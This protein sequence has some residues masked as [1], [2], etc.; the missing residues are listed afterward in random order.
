LFVVL[1]V[2]IAFA[3]PVLGVLVARGQ[4]SGAEAHERALTKDRHPVAAVL[5]QDVFAIGG[6][7][8]GTSGVS[9]DVS[10]TAADGTTHTGKADVQTVGRLG[11]PTT[12]WLNAA[13][14]PTDPPPTHDRLVVDAVGGAALLVFTGAGALTA[15]YLVERALF[16]RLRMRAWA[17]DWSRTAPTWTPSA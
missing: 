13:G 2:L 11:D 9:A 8:Q 15:L 7:M 1:I 10:W 14:Q 6:W 3:L 12:I 17:K 4:L 16:M 5:K